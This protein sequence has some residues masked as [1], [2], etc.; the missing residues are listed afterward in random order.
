[1]LFKIIIIF[2]SIV[3]FSSS[4]TLSALTLCLVFSGYLILLIIFNPYSQSQANQIEKILTI[5]LIS[6]AFLTIYT[7]DSNG[8]WLSIVSL[9]LAVGI[10]VI[11]FGFL[12]YKILMI[13]LEE[14]RLKKV[15]NIE[16]SNE[17]QLKQEIN[18]SPL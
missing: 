11:M 1:M 17:N 6:T 14:M 16:D 2:T 5:T 18:E 10:N 4:G 7:I 8:S 3:I 9:T 12:V 13:R 15:K